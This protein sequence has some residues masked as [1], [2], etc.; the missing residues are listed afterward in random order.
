[1][2]ITVGGGQQG[3]TAGSTAASQLQD[4]RFDPELGL[5]SVWRTECSPR[6]CVDQR[7]C[8]VP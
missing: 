7:V 1:M 6:V 2:Y 8:M 4:R 5:V 3:G